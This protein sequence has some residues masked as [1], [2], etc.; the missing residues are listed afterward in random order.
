MD[1]YGCVYISVFA[2]R[3]HQSDEE[4]SN[5]FVD[6]KISKIINALGDDY[7]FI[8]NTIGTRII[9]FKE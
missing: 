1:K 8:P 9:E 6:A 7:K 4:P 3:R 2:Q 5:N